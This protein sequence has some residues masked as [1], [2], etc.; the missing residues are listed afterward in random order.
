[1]NPEQT[2]QSVFSAIQ[3]QNF[4]AALALLSEDFTFS[5]GTPVPVNKQEWIGVHR[6]L[7]AAIPDLVMGYK[8][9]KVNGSTVSG[10]V[11][12][13]GTHKGELLLPLPGLPPVPATGNTISLPQEKVEV[14][15]RNGQVTAIV[16]EDLPNGG[17]KS[18]LKQMGAA[19]PQH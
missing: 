6:A 2:V 5:G 8:T 4:D 13:K 3:A 14:S 16:V 17:L 9:S 12:L 1:M 19:L 18:I 15:V 11:Q 10:S 7:G